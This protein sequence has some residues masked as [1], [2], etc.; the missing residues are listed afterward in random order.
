MVLIESFSGIRGIYE[1]EITKEIIE[2][3]SLAYISLLN[4]KYPNKKLKVVIGRDTRKSGKEILKIITDNLDCEIIDVGIMPTPI[5]E[6][7]VRAFGAEGGIIITAS[8]NE[9]DFNG[10]KFLDKDG[11]VLRPKDINFVINE[12]KFIK[13]IYQKNKNSKITNREREA[14]KEYEDILKEI[15]KI[16]KIE[17]KVKIIVDANGGSGIVS[18]EIFDNFGVNAYYINLDAGEFK[19]LIEPK[20]ESLKYLEEYIKEQN[21][22]FAVGFDC[23][24]DRVEILLNNGELVSGNY[25]LALIAEEILSENNGPVVVNDATSYIVKEIAEKHN[26]KFKEVEV[27]EINVVDEMLALNSPV[28]GEGSNGGVIIPPLR[29]RDGILTTLL[30]L[31]II[32]KKNK[33]LKELI[34]ELPRYYYLKEKIN[35]KEDFVEIKN[36][37]REHYLNRKFQI[38]ETGDKT[39]GLKAIKNNSWV[40]FRQSKT[41]DKVL[42]IIVDSKDKNIAE[43]LLNEAKNLLFR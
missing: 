31:K 28:G 2:K 8:H 33:S 42:R 20:E 24:A 14:L 39:G 3:Y 40:W 43:E 15:L 11:A 21:A 10:F 27:G 16:E 13:G 25:I 1:K 30:L 38:L 22:S 4:K 36:K 29:C 12:A 6:N 35:I 7:A 9:P 41:E 37:I 23:D 18:K 17:S 19:R 32:S 34:E 5:I 26:S